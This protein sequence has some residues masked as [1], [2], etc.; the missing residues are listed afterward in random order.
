MFCLRLF[1]IQHKRNAVIAFNSNV[2]DDKSYVARSATVFIGM[3]ILFVSAAALNGCT[4]QGVDPVRTRP[5]LYLAKWGAV[6]GSID[7]VD[8]TNDSLIGVISDSTFRQVLTIN[9]A[10]EGRYLLIKR[11]YDGSVLWDAEAG[12]ETARIGEDIR[13]AGFGNGLG[14]LVGIGPDS[15]YVYQLPSAELI[16]SF[17]STLQHG[18]VRPGRTEVI[19]G[20]EPTLYVVDYLT[21]HVVDSIEVDDIAGADVQATAFAIS[22]NGDRLYIKAL[23]PRIGYSVLCYDLDADSVVFRISTYIISSISVSSDGAELWVTES[24]LSGPGSVLV[25]SAINGDFYTRIGTEEFGGLLVD[26]IEFCD[27]LDKV[28]VRSLY[29]SPILVI[30]RSSRTIL[31][32]FKPSGGSAYSSMGLLKHMPRTSTGTP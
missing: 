10:P 32:S 19:G 5:L 2:R 3:L 15:M 9:S 11:S 4:D 7:I 12:V 20:H 1:D 22:P 28:Y 26:E 29:V 31:D 24:G 18:I 25:C 6:N 27:E 13:S 23:K 21:G 17:A 16:R 14:M 30:D 8:C